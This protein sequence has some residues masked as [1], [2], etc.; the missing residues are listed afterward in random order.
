MSRDET[1]LTISDAAR[2]CGMAASTLRYHANCGRIAC[3]RSSRA[4]RMF[5]RA[6]VLK[7]REE[8]YQRG[9]RRR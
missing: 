4:D 2:L 7:F 6:D 9:A 8:R 1:L 5:V 3:Q